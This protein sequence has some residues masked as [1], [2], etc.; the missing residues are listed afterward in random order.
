MGARVAKWVWPGVRLLGALDRDPA[1]AVR[2]RVQL[3]RLQE[4]AVRREQRALRVVTV[5][6]EA[7]ARAL[8]ERFRR[9][10]HAVG[11][12]HQRVGRKVVRQRLQVVEEQP[13]PVLDAG[14]GEPLADVAVHRAAVG[15][16]LER[17]P[18]A[19][20]ERR[21]R[22]RVQRELARG[23]QPQLLHPVAGTLGLRVEDADALDLVA[24][25]VQP[26]R[27]PRSHREEVQQRAAHRE[28]AVLHDLP[29][30]TVAGLLE[31]PAE[32]RD[33]EALTAFQHHAV[34]VHEAPWRHPGHQRGHRH[35]QHAAP[36]EGQPVQCL[37]A[38]GDDVLVRR[39]LVVGQGL[40]V[41]EVQHRKG[42]VAG[43]EE[44]QLGAGAVGG[45]AVGDHEDGEPVVG[46][47]GAGHR[48]AL[49]A[50]VQP[51]PAHAL[52]RGA[53]E[54]G[55]QRRDGGIGHVR[56]Q[57]E[58]ARDCP[59]APAGPQGRTRAPEA[60]SSGGRRQRS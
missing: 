25:Q 46:A 37:Q 4:H 14:R 18:P 48:E 32:G 21:H 36:G 12:D 23:Q 50:A 40:P 31:A 10:V 20:A 3:A 26:V 11:L 8:P 2:R 60:L 29:H 34:A 15:V 30:A 28:L 43:A 39:E 44:A 7:L 35:H 53:G 45:G 13:E 19:L 58:E 9:G 17:R 47:G 6:L 56:A 27:L 54:G 41:R 38:L 42:V 22:V 52:A 16:A 49:G 51:A 33:V 55:R 5:L 24:E 1:V 59:G 57:A